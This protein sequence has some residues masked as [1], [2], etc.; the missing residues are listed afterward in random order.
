MGHLVQPRGDHGMLAGSSTWWVSWGCLQTTARC[1]S[2]RQLP[3]GRAEPGKVRPEKAPAFWGDFLEGVVIPHQNGDEEVR[4]HS[5]PFAG[6]GSR[7]VC[8]GGRAWGSHEWA[9]LERMDLI[10][11]KDDHN[12]SLIWAGLRFI[13][14]LNC[15]QFKR[16]WSITPQMVI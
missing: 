5:H 14:L 13:E 6:R 1:L 10:M 2:A 9:R 16:P 3:L 4:A 8:G 12:D 11:P 15:V 7:I